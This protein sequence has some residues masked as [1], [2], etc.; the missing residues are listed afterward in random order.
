MCGSCGL[1][2][3]IEGSP[4]PTVPPAP[5][6]IEIVEV[7]PAVS[8]WLEREPR[9]L[10]PSGEP[11]PEELRARK[12][13][14]VLT[15]AAVA[16]TIAFAA[17]AGLAGY[18]EASRQF[19]QRQAEEGARTQQNEARLTALKDRQEQER[20]AAEAARAVAERQTRLITAKYLAA[21]AGDATK[22]Q[23]WRAVAMA[24][25]S[26]K[27][28]LVH[29]NVLLPEA[30]QS[31]RDA[32]AECPPVYGLDGVALGGHAGGV[33]A[34]A[35]SPDGR[36]L[37]TGSA[38]HK[39]RLWDLRSEQRKH[40]AII[41]KKH[42]GAVSHVLFSNDG[43]W[44]ITGGRDSTVCL[45]DIATA[46]SH[47][48]PVVLPGRDGRIGNMAI[49]ANGRWLAIV[50]ASVHGKSDAAMLWDLGAGAERATS[51][52]L[53]GA[54]GRIQALAISP[55]SRWLAL[56]VDGAIHLWDL[57]ASVPAIA[58]ISRRCQHGVAAAMFSNDGKWL[59]TSPLENA[60]GNEAAAQLWDLSAS[61]PSTSI[62]LRGHAAPVKTLTIS[63]DSRWLVTA[64]NDKTARV[65]DLHAGDPSAAHR[66]VHTGKNPLTAA[67]ISA[68]GRWLAASESSGNVRLWY[69]AAGPDASAIVL[70]GDA[71]N[72]TRLAFTP[73]MNWLAAAGGDRSVR[74]WN[75]DIH[76]LMNRATA[77]AMAR[78]ESV[79]ARYA[80]LHP[81]QTVV[82][83]LLLEQVADSKCAFVLSAARDA[84]AELQAN[85]ASMV[86]I[87]GTVWS[88][89]R[90]LMQS[91]SQFAD[92]AP[93][94]EIAQVT[95]GAVPDLADETLAHAE[96]T[97][98]TP[99]PAD[100][101]IEDATAP[102]AASTP[103][104]ALQTNTLRIFVR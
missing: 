55:N 76:D 16:A 97:A 94:I 3:T 28:T 90:D 101:T 5:T 62:V 81:S 26:V 71:I 45:W 25:E 64:A 100:L 2:S 17:L 63:G 4:S 98:I 44:L 68:D 91:M 9:P 35:A 92:S 88:G 8:H 96:S 14:R 30:H 50:F 84:S 10:Q 19:S 85:S 102:A 1:R 83:A 65:W 24:I 104:T 18:Q 47:L 38:D 46:S 23:C 37:A 20:Q 74:I 13:R 56:G 32:L 87:A 95:D 86:A 53:N 48:S 82:G 58:S 22:A 59:V 27:A 40:P 66:I 69:L 11:T 42:A 33:T 39:V 67:A 77:V 12:R 31:L 6:V 79:A 29:D 57:D 36:W 15:T 7:P 52:E 49:S 61:D 75:V 51:L 73:D 41:L 93:T 103:R 70:R 89:F 43:R 72:Q 78:R 21:Q 80:W 34:M 99:T 54:G 60:A